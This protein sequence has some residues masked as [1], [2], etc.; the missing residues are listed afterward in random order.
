MLHYG[1]EQ[2]SDDSQDYRKDEP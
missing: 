1:S 2:G